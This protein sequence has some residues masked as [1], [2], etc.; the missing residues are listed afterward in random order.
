MSTIID[1]KEVMSITSLSRSSIYAL[2]KK[3]EF[4]N[5]IKLSS[6]RVGWVR[7]EV[8]ALIQDRSNARR[9]EY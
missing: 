1:I 3:G 4:P 6:R 8:D 9:L 2:M 7:S 5:Q